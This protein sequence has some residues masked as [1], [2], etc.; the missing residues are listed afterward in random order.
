MDEYLNELIA[1]LVIGAGVV[2]VA[3][4]GFVSL[5]RRLRIRRSTRRHRLSGARLPD[6]PALVVVP[7]EEVRSEPGM[8]EVVAADVPESHALDFFDAFEDRLAQIRAE[9]EA[10]D[11]SSAR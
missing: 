9:I 8:T 11:T 5:R 3:I 1:Y 2:F 10:L 4:A 7:A 6:R